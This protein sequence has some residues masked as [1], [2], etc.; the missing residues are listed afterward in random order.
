MKFVLG[1]AFTPT[2]YLPELAI[3]ADRNGWAMMAISDHTVSPESVKAKYPYAADGDRFWPPFTE[4]PDATVMMGAFSGLTK[5]LKFTTSVY[6]LPA[7]N[8][9]HVANAFATVSA[10]SNNRVV[11]T[12]GVGWCKDEFDLLQQDFSTRGKRCDEMIEI[13]RLLWT[14]EYVEYQGNHYQFDR[15]EINPRPTGNIPIWIGG[16]TEP[17]LRRAARLGDGWMPAGLSASEIADGVKRIRQYR[18]EYGRD[19][20]GFDV[21]LSPKNESDRD[22]YKRLGDLGVT[23][24]MTQPWRMY[25]AKPGDLQAMKDSVVRFSDEIISRF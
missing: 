18:G 8:P 11:L 16:N 20:G 3:T 14:G 19:P 2:A 22:G 6:V 25:D 1:G 24:I 23:H 21:M 13:L 7:R 9:F 12:I 15:V 17:A 10:I 5:N 4:W